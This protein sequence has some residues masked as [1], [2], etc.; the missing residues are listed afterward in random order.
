[1]HHSCLSTRD[2]GYRTRECRKA[3]GAEHVFLRLLNQTKAAI[4]SSDNLNNEILSNSLQ[5][6]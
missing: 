2:G 3:L 6:S 5:S 4:S 1:M